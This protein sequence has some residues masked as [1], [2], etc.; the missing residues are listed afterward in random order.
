MLGKTSSLNGLLSAGTGCAAPSLE[1]FHSPVDVTLG[2]VVSG[3]PGSAGERLDL[4]GSE[5]I[6][7]PTVLCF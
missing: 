6:P 7:T 5:V 4:V 3:G 1:G 2:D